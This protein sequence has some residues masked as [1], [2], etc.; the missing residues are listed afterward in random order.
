MSVRAY[1]EI[2]T[3]IVGAGI[4]GLTAALHLYQAGKNVCVLEASDDVGGRMKTDRVDGFL[5]DHG[6]QVYNTAYPEGKELLDF[7]ALS[8]K[9]F[10]SGATIHTKDA[11]GRPKATSVFDPV[12]HPMSLLS[13]LSSAFSKIGTFKDKCLTLRLR[14]EL[15]KNSIETFMA[16]YDVQPSQ[17]TFDFLHQYGFTPN[18]VQ[19]FFVPFFGGVF[20]DDDLTTSVEEFLW[21][22]RM[23]CLGKAA[24]PKD[25]MGTIPKQLASRLPNGCIQFQ[26]T[27]KECSSSQLTLD[28]G[29]TLQAKNIVVATDV[30]SAKKIMKEPLEELTKGTR[31]F[32]FA[33]D[34]L[35]SDLPILHLN[36]TGMGVISH[37]S[38]PSLVQS[39]YAPSG[40]YLMTVSTNRPLSQPISPKDIV[41][42]MIEVLG[43]KSA[44]QWTHLKTYTLPY[45]L[46]KLKAHKNMGHPPGAGCEYQRM[47]YEKTGIVFCGDYMGPPSINEAIASGRRAAELILNLSQKES[48]A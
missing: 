32:Y 28:D 11:K 8:L 12:Q 20:L 25:G 27:V 40:Q 45:A 22:Y 30:H 17:S 10:Y 47:Q 46:P 3:L 33:S 23:F 4:S 6:F 34:V 42:E 37:W 13:S 29:Q 19:A 41:H 31:T 38:V 7:E 14:Y 5:L 36:G 15:E 2:D 44:S 9:S 16:R 24:L 21:S 18:F 35:P 48:E 43:V 26:K 39:S 1:D